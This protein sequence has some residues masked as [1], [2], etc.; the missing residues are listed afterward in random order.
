[1]TEI[2][3][4]YRGWSLVVM[5]CALIRNVSYAERNSRNRPEKVRDF[6]EI[7]GAWLL[8]HLLPQKLL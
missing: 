7:E 2:V 6:A 4:N 1:M 3:R 8:S 5:H